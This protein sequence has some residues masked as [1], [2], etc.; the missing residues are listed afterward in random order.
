MGGE[1]E[2]EGGEENA[3]FRLALPE[4]RGRMGKLRRAPA[5]SIKNFKGGNNFIGGIKLDGQ[6]AAAHLGDALR[7]PLRRYANA[8]CVFRPGSDHFPFPHTAG[9]G[10]ACK[11]PRGGEAG[12]AGGKKIPA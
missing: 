12:G 10:G 3:G 8:R 11:A 4:E 1:A 5:D 7:K 9:E 2:G 6:P